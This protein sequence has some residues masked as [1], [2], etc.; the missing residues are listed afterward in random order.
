MCLCIAVKGCIRYRI[1][2]SFNSFCNSFRLC[3]VHAIQIK[4]IHIKA[5]VMLYLFDK[6]RDNKQLSSTQQSVH[7]VWFV[8]FMC[9]LYLKMLKWIYVN[10][11][12]YEANGT[13]SESYFRCAWFLAIFH[14]LFCTVNRINRRYKILCCQLFLCCKTY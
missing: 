3:S 1:V 14:I 6:A 9:G 4:C 11:S 2:F 13:V 10:H 5:G 7:T 8:I 12:K